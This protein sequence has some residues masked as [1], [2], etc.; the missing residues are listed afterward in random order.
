MTD[1]SK[2][3]LFL[4]KSFT[5]GGVSGMT[6]KTAIAPLERLKILL[7]AHNRHYKQH[8]VISGLV[9]IYRKEGFLGFYKGNGAMMVRI[10]PYDSIKFGSYEQYKKLTSYYL[11]PKNEIG[12]LLNGALAGVTAV[13]CTYPLDMIRARLAFQVKGEHIYNGIIDAIKSIYKKEGGL[14]ALYSGYTPTILGIMPYGALSFYT[15]EN[16]KYFCLHYAPNILGKPSPNNKDEI[17]LRI[18]AS[19]LCGG[20]G[21]AAA[22]TISFPLD[23]AR[24]RMQLAQ[25]LP[26]SKEFSN[27]FKTLGTVY[28][29]DGIVKGLYRGLSI[30]YVR[31]VPQV[32]VSFATYEVMKQV[33][34]LKTGV[35]KN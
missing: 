32:A 5:S 19:L 15:F 11:G 6:S 35:Q 29:K 13:T 34:N 12:K 18:P 8:G 4:V 16:M 27:V 24:R 7:Q 1:D 30:N 14:R 10:F 28:R 21:G 17:V 20:L 9:A 2:S 22:Q 26:D 33:F 25:I 3:V 23:V 31:V